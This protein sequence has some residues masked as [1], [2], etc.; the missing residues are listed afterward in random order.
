MGAVP[1]L[2]TTVLDGLP[3]D[4]HKIAGHAR[5]LG[6]TGL[7]NYLPNSNTATRQGQMIIG[8]TV[9]SPPFPCGGETL[10]TRRTDIAGACSATARAPVSTAAAGELCTATVSGPSKSL[11]AICTGSKL[12]HMRWK[13]RGTSGKGHRM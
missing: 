9:L 1:I 12:P 8:S 2:L 4:R 6:V 5:R 7:G 10:W 11:S 13:W 3:N